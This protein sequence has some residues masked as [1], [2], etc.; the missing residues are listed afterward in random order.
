MLCLCVCHRL[1]YL[2]QVLSPGIHAEQRNQISFHTTLQGRT[3]RVV[4]EGGGGL[5]F[6]I[7]YFFIYFTFF[8][9]VFKFFNILLVTIGT[10]ETYF[11]CYGRN[12][13][14]LC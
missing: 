8:I 11:V 10:A 6:Y 3:G 12:I 14:K 4:F 9:T 1:K 2:V 7:I 5:S 13:A